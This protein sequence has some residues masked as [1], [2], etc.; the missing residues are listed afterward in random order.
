MGIEFV[1]L[2]ALGVVQLVQQ[3]SLWSDAYPKVVEQPALPPSVA[4]QGT[5]LT[6]VG[7]TFG[8]MPEVRLWMLTEDEH[9]LLQLQHDRLILNWRKLGG[10]RYP[11]F[12][13]M[14]PEFLLRWQQFATS[15][16]NLGPLR[17][18]IADVTFVNQIYSETTPADLSE[19]LVSA[20]PILV[21]EFAKLQETRAQVVCQVTH[22]GAGQGHL[23]IRAEPGAA[24]TVQLTLT[25]RLGLP[26]D[27]PDLE[28]V[29]TAIEA[30]H[31][32]GVL[33]FTQ[34]TTSKMHETWRRKQ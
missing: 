29:K 23:V 32:T 28:A 22:P 7:L 8:S 9:M 1:P 14:M 3:H 34:A 5:V 25:T 13:K 20:N 24:E 27:E 15:V 12:A 18:A 31:A 30:A 19:I 16:Q 11:S 2:Q 33:A 6:S 10:D 17:P 21:P 4:P 26:G